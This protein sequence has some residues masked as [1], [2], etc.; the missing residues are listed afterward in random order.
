MKL[1][2]D[3]TEEEI[4][5]EIAEFTEMVFSSYSEII[6]TL[7]NK[8]WTVEEFLEKIYPSMKCD[9]EE[10]GMYFHN[11]INQAKKLFQTDSVVEIYRYSTKELNEILE[12]Y[13]GVTIIS[14]FKDIFSLLEI[15]ENKILFPEKWFSPNIYKQVT[16]FLK[17]FD[18]ERCKIKKQTGFTNKGEFTNEQILQIGKDLEGVS[19]STKFDFF[20]TPKELVQKVQQ[21]GE[22]KENDTILEPSA[23]IG[24][25]IAGLSKENIQCVEINPILASILKN[26][27]YKVCNKSF[28]EVKSSTKFDKVLMNPPFSKRLDAKHIKLAFD[29]YLENNGVLVAIHSAGILTAQDKDSKQFQELYNKYGEAQIKI[30]AGAFKE[31]GKGTNIE[32]IITKL[33][34]VA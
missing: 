11:I 4:K 29:N 28:E 33:R 18:C 9:I 30:P 16:E 3:M 34:K 13:H 1:I 15:K 27:G 26:K 24:S 6:N 31:S 21:L 23:G 17:T 22:I 10:E 2:T 20:P 5:Q 14:D 25:L 7:K 12:T 32:T 19:L 8:T